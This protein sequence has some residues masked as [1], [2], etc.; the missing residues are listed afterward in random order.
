MQRLLSLVGPTAA[1][2]VLAACGPQLPLGDGVDRALGGKAEALD[3]ANDPSNLFDE[4]AEPEHRRYFGTIAGGQVYGREILTE[5]WLMREGGLAAPLDELLSPIASY[6]LL[7]RHRGAQQQRLFVRAGCGGQAVG[8]DRCRTWSYD[9]WQSHIVGKHGARAF[10]RFS[11]DLLPPSFPANGG[12]VRQRPLVIGPATAWEHAYHGELRA[13]WPR[14]WRGH[15]N[16][17]TGYHLSDEPVPR[18][19]L[20]VRFDGERLIRCEQGTPRC[21]HF[22]K[23]ALGG[24]M[25][26]LH[27]NATTS[28]LGER[29]N[30]AVPGRTDGQLTVSSC[31]DLNPAAW[32][33]AV[34]AL[35]GSNAVNGARI[36]MDDAAAAPVWNYPIAAYGILEQ[37]DARP[38]EI[39]Q[40][41]SNSRGVTFKYVKMAFANE[42]AWTSLVRAQ[43]R[44]S[45]NDALLIGAARTL[46]Y[47]LEVDSD[48]Q[49]VGGSWLGFNREHHPDMLWTMHNHRGG[50]EDADDLGPQDPEKWRPW[51]DNPF[52]SYAHVRALIACA[53]S[54]RPSCPAALPR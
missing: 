38:E 43:F 2:L 23:R 35:I 24:L 44:A 26:E 34:T 6:E 17:W 9:E 31:R 3:K 11:S 54:S 49:I 5:I 52:L 16:G 14:D 47:L 18:A 50:K 30:E 27:F 29:C 39:E 42:P 8:D 25:S 32:H 40:G 48:G 7:F 21:V 22:S 10:E 1:L 28:T 37:R 15:C 51:M 36:A 4:L 46:E 45:I 41:Y 19:A 20:S 53:N 12:T 13:M 33:I